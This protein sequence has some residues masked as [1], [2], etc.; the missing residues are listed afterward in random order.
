M[1]NYEDKA[2]LKKL[3]LNVLVLVGIVIVLIIIASMVA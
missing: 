2:T 1:T 3:G